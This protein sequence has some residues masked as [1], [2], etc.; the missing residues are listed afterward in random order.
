MGLVDIYLKCVAVFF[1]PLAIVNIY[2]N[3]IQGMGYGLLPMMAGVAELAGRG[4]MAV[5]AADRKSYVGVCLANP[6]AWILAGVLLIVMYF[7]IMNHDM[8][9]FGDTRKR[10]E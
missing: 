3:G 5:A 8:K 7:Y 10:T 6:A 9:K 2:R 1:I 4:L